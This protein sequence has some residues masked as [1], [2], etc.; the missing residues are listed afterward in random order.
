M[1]ITLIDQALLIEPNDPI[2]QNIKYM[3]DKVITGK[4]KRPSIEDMIV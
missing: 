4:I 1:A 2:N 3:I